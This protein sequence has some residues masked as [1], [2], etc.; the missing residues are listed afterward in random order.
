MTAIQ[1]VSAAT[2]DEAPG[3][4]RTVSQAFLHDPTWAWAFPDPLARAQ[5]WSL[6]IRSAMRYPLVLKSPSFEVVAVWIPPDSSELTHEEEHA[7]PRRLAEL[8]P[9]READVLELLRRFEA[10]HPRDVPHVYLS[11]L[12]TADEHRGKGL[13]MALLRENLARF[14]AEGVPTYLESSNPA[15]NHRYEAVGFREVSRFDVP[16]GSHYVT[17]MW[18]E[19]GDVP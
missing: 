6:H 9:S 8:T 12:A 4:I 15:N 13:G 5:W 10:A 19:A 14:D 1:N 7:I 18:R 11:L 17:G 16:G 3:V 2:L